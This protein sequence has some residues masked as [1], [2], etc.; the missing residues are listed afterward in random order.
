M[1]GQNW[2]A[3][4]N[5]VTSAG[6][7]EPKVAIGNASPNYQVTVVWKGPG[8]N[9]NTVVYAAG[10]ILG[11]AWS[12]PAVI[13]GQVEN[14]SS[15]QVAVDGQGNSLALWFT[16]STDQR[17]N[18]SVT[19]DSAYLA[20]NG[21]WTAPVAVSN[22]G[23][24][25][26]ES[27]MLQVSYDPLGNALAVWTISFDDTTYNVQ[28]SLLPVNKSWTNPLTQV[29]QDL[30]SYQFGYALNTLGNAYLCTMRYDNSSHYQYIVVNSS[31]VGG[32]LSQAWSNFDIISSGTSNGYPVLAAS[33]TSPN[34]GAIAAAWIFNNGSN[35]VINVSIG[36]DP[37]VAPATNLGVTQNLKTV[38]VVTE[39][40]NTLTWQDSTAA[41]AKNYT[42]YRNG[43]LMGFVLP[44]VMMWVD[45]NRI[46][47]DVNIYSVSVLDSSNSQSAAA[48][49]NF[50]NTPLP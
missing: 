14:V 37:V 43:V 2:Q 48:T 47:G 49:I 41:T 46:P 16:S 4:P 6:A 45:D 31:L 36:A 30:Y 8:M 15:P 23:S 9:S 1:F 42:I 29:L 12:A 32:N 33:Q 34:A 38:G 35:N 28:S 50:Q 44:G 26:P 13:S 27:L 25:N 24:R 5:I 18:T 10:A 19:V 17:N 20:L 7:Q 40:Y 3:L 11:G 22:A 39:Y 21:S